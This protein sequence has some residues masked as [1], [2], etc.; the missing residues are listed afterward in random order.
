MKT[1][2][3]F[4]PSLLDDSDLAEVGDSVKPHSKMS[5]NTDMLVAVI[6]LGILFG[7]SIISLIAFIIYFNKK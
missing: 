2:K 6:V 3:Y 1:N 4:F 5:P 7:G